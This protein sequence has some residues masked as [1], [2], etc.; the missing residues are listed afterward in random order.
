M[1][2]GREKG[3]EEI[4]EASGIVTLGWLVDFDQ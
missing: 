2:A 3:R 4:M 1:K